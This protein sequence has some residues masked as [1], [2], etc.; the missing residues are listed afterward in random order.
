MKITIGF[1]IGYILS[2]IIIAKIDRKHI[3]KTPVTP[4]LKIKCD[5]NKCDTLYVY[6][7]E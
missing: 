6:K 7:F 2:A 3:V 5:N 1:L 4:S